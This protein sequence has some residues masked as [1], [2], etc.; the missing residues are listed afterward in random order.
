MR[1]LE[2]NV[3][4]LVQFLEQAYDVQIDS[5]LETILCKEMRVTIQRFT[6]ENFI[7]VED[8]EFEA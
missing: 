3:S 6:I 7:A 4:T 5:M 2:S 8:V 1:L